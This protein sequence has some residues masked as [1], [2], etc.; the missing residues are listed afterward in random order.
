MDDVKERP[1]PRRDPSLTEMPVEEAVA[2]LMRVYG[3]D[4][5]TARLM[6]G[7]ARG[8]L[9][10]DALSVADPA[11]DPPLSQLRSGNARAS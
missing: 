4:E 3:E 8:D 7:V 5:A 1:A 2:F 6:V 11:V 9:E 10:G